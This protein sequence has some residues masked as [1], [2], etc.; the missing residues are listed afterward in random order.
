MSFLGLVLVSAIESAD[1]DV[2]A[3][4]HGSGASPA[5]AQESA[6]DAEGT[7][8]API[9]DHVTAERIHTSEFTSDISFQTHYPPFFLVN[10]N[11]CVCVCVRSSRDRDRER[12]SKHSS[13]ERRS[14][15]LNGRIDSRRHDDREAGE[16]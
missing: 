13:S 15:G 2:P 16:I 1:A 5:L 14:D 8:L 3:P 12:D 11:V 6:T 9:P 4:H 7:D 10:L